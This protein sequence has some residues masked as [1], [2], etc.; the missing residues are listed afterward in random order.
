MEELRDEVKEFEQYRVL[1]FSDVRGL[2]CSVDSE[3]QIKLKKGGGQNLRFHAFYCST[4][5]WQEMGKPRSN[6]WEPGVIKRHC[7][8]ESERE[9]MRDRGYVRGKIGN[10]T[11]TS[12]D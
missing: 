4:E 6:P 10:L 8:T 11:G 7:G 9:I 5:Q 2:L 12:K 1:E 3:T